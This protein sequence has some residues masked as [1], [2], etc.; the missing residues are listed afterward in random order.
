LSFRKLKILLTGS[1]GTIGSTLKPLLIQNGFEVFCWDRD[2][3]PIDNYQL[4]EDYVVK[5]KPYAL[6]HLAA[7]TSFDPEKRRDSW[8]ENYEWTSELAWICHKF[9]I[10]FVYTSSVMVFTGD[11]P[12]PHNVEEVPGAGSGYGYEKRMSETRV[13]HQNPDAIVLRLGW[14]IGNEGKNT[15]VGYL[16]DTFNKLSCIPASINWFTACSFLGDTCKVIIESLGYPPGLF[17]VDSNVKWN[18]YEIACALK[19]YYKKPWKIIPAEHPVIDH[20]MI[21]GRVKI[22]VLDQCLVFENSEHNG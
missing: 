5:I 8:L 11:T 20:R 22:Q 19:E 2:A 21:D 14:Q 12:G 9:G 3:V 15:L 17:Q 6:I 1:S 13:F 10:R 7:N 4:M 16:D 18:F